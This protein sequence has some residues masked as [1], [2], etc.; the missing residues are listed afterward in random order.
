M[1]Y[2]PSLAKFKKDMTS[3]RARLRVDARQAML[4][5]AEEVAENMRS[6]APKDEGSLAESVRV[7]D[8]SKSFANRTTLS[9]KILA[10]GPL[11]LRR[12]RKSGEVYDYAMANEFGTREMQAQPFFYNTFRRYQQIFPGQ[13]AETLKESIEANNAIVARRASGVAGPSGRASR[14]GGVVIRSKK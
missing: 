11:T 6:A 1:A 13:M 8:V 2:N 3:I 5:I 12:N 14:K 9:V 7:V 4:N 10:G